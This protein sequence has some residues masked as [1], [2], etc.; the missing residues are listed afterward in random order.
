ML[1]PDIGEA[2]E[3]SSPPLPAFGRYQQQR[4]TRARTVP[5]Q[6]ASLE[7]GVLK[8]QIHQKLKDD[9]VLSSLKAIVSSVLSNNTSRK[10]HSYNKL[11]AEPSAEDHNRCVRA[12]E[13][14][15]HERSAR[16]KGVPFCG[17]SGLRSERAKRARRRHSLLRWKQAR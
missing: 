7:M 15:G 10:K 11:I 9:G 13:R 6:M 14:S 12:S 8:E 5:N 1:V 17:G 16:N 4:P 2:G 3:K